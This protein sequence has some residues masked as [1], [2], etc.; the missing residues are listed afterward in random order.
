MNAIWN[1]FLERRQFTILV[2]VS[3]VIAGTISVLA[4][5]KESTPEVTVPIAVITT[6]LRGASPE[7]VAKLVTKEVEKE[8]ATVSNIDT[9]TSSSR[10]GISFVTVQFDASADLEKSIQDVKDAVD[11]AKASLPRDADDPMVAQVDF[12]NEPVLMFSLSGG[13][14]PAEFNRLSKE[15]TDEL[16][17]IPGISRVEASGVRERE[18][19][20]ILRKEALASYGITSAEVLGAIQ[21]ANAALPVGS[22]SVDGTEYSINFKGGLEDPKDLYQVIVGSA[23]GRPVYLSDVSDIVDGIER[24]RSFARV[25]I[26]AQPA[27]PAINMMVYKQSGGDIIAVVGKVEKELEE[28]QKT[29]GTLDGIAVLT[30]YSAAEEVTDS[31]TEL[32]RVGIETMILVMLVL[33]LTI[34]W[35]ESVVAGLS[36]PLSFV[37]AFIGLYASGNTINFVSLFSLILAIG[38]LVDSG[39]VVTEAIHTRFKKFGDPLL[40]AKEAIREYAWPLTAGTMA[41]VAFFIPLFFI[42]GITGEFIKSIPFT[43]IFVLIASLVVALGFVPLIA[44]M[45]TKSEMNALEKKQEELNEKFN[46]WYRGW[47]MGILKDKKFQRRFVWGVMGVFLLS[48]VMPMTGLVKTIFF[49]GDDMDLMYVEIEALQGT[50]L[51][52]TDLAAR[53]VEEILYENPNIESFATTIGASSAFNQNGSSGNGKL[54]NIT[55]NLVPKEK[56]KKSSSEL[57]TEIAKSLESFRTFKVSVYEPEGG[58]PSGAPVVVKFKGENL[59]DLTRA[60]DIGERIMTSIEGTR[61]VTASNR[62]NGSGFTLSIDR[63]KAAQVGLSPAQVAGTLRTAVSG[64]VATTIVKDDGDIDVLVLTNLNADWRE[65]SETNDTTIDAIQNLSIS[66]P[67]GQILLG[68]LLVSS[69]DQA[70]ASISREDQENVASVSSYL[71]EGAN[72][73]TITQE[74][75]RLI[76]AETLPETVTVTLGGETENVDQSFAEM[77]YALLGGIVLTFAILVLAFNSFRFSWYLIVLI[78]Y[79]LIGVMAG[80]FLTGSPLS[81]PSLLGVI[82]LAGVIINHAIILVDSIIIRMKDAKDR[83]LEEVIV[84]AAASRLRPIVLTTLTTVIGMVPLSAASGLWGPLAFAIMFGLTFAMVLTLVLTPILVFRNPGKVYWK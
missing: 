12:A 62:D 28:M 22:I 70:N 84:D 31:L 6:T 73:L 3:L 24:A 47:L 29:G 51:E 46:L 49:P 14:P 75:K 25:S 82:A 21:S 54:A 44:I 67:R 18:A 23:G 30:T 57:R 4:M 78:P 5:P 11:R 7:D 39:I 72:A 17:K 77:G 63:A 40:A 69:L 56:R 61:D 20:I 36:V 64:S 9:L 19:Q 42:S 60:V 1:F 83:S 80:L 68:S 27:E 76:A 26:D 38:I 43:I 65:P 52:R 59:D 50:P 41:T 8:V 32:T 2:I 79:S 55:V 13:L 16:E 71:K 34:G 35:R 45:F 53:A 10:E 58:P 37:I 66:T 81:F 33:F 74:F 48:L 15:V